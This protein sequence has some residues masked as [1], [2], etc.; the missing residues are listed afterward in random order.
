MQEY[1]SPKKKSSYH[2]S[3]NAYYKHIE[4]INLE[5]TQSLSNLFI[6]TP[7]SGKPAILKPLKLWK[8]PGQQQ[9]KEKLVWVYGNPW[10][11]TEPKYLKTDGG[12]LEKIDPLPNAVIGKQLSKPFD[13][14][15][16][17]KLTD[18]EVTKSAKINNSEE[19]EKSNIVSVEERQRSL[20]KKATIH[21]SKSDVTLNR[22][23]LSPLETETEDKT[24]SDINSERDE[25]QEADYGSLGDNLKALSE[26][27]ESSDQKMVE[28]HS[29]RN[30]LETEECNNTQKEAIVISE[31]PKQIVIK[32]DEDATSDTNGNDCE[33]SVVEESEAKNEI[34]PTS[35]TDDVLKEERDSES[36]SLSSESSY[37]EGRKDGD[38]TKETFNEETVIENDLHLSDAEDGDID[39]D[40]EVLKHFGDEPDPYVDSE[41]DVLAEVTNPPEEAETNDILTMLEESHGL[42]LEPNLTSS[43]STSFG[44]TVD[45]LVANFST[46]YVNENKD[47]STAADFSSFNWKPNVEFFKFNDNSK[48]SED[49]FRF[50]KATPQP[51]PILPKKKFSDSIRHRSRS[52][53]RFQ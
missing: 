12:K 25:R 4:R 3:V 16:P 15:L 31:D 48:S 2:R 30:D 28:P 45:Q 23:G 52:H 14:E 44:A 38:Q 13:P 9:G 43:K 18:K 46:K 32:D 22:V 51:P 11:Q 53:P 27:D 49:V 21:N 33:S 35:P 47:R 37:K 26:P 10:N 40:D 24:K 1:F 6:K 20:E 39:I 19:D 36:A 8:H 5:R 17:S 42:G 34:P 29:P 41:E 7:K 50:S